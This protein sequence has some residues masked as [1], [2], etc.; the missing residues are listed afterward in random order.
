MLFVAMF[1]LLSPL[2]VD[3]RQ[4]HL[5]G[6]DEAQ[7]EVH[8]DL[9]NGLIEP[10]P[11]V[12]PDEFDRVTALVAAVAVPAGLVNLQGGSLLTVEGAADVSAAV[13]FETV[14]F[15][16]LSGG[17]ALLDDR[18]GFHDGH[19]SSLLGSVRMS[20]IRAPVSSLSQKWNSTPYLV[21]M[22]WIAL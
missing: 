3:I 11:L 19:D 20:M 10:A 17:D 1:L 5:L 21:A 15:H 9:G 7:V 18:G 14:V 13:G 8:I 12:Q 6:L 2:A 4:G 16:D 22:V